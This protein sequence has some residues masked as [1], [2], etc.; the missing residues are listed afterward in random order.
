[1]YL[2]T[3]NDENAIALYESAK[4]GISYS[5]FQVMPLSDPQPCYGI[6]PAAQDNNLSVEPYQG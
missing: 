2:N 3:H 1:M 4:D 6:L 5:S